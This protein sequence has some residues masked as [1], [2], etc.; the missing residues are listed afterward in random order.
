MSN[1]VMKA[2][3]GAPKTKLDIGKEMDAG[4]VILINNSKSVLG[5]EGAEFFGRFFVALILAAAEQRSGRPDKE[6]LPCYVYIDECQ[7]VIKRDT[8]IATI[9]DE[10]RSQKI[11]LILAHQRTEQIKDI[12]VLSALSN[13]AIRFA[14]SDDEA[15]Y[16]ADKLRTSQE[17]LR[18][19]DRGY[20]AAFVRDVTPSAVAIEVLPVD[21]SEY[22]Q[23][24][25]D[26]I[27]AIRGRMRLQYGASGVPP[28]PPASPPPPPSPATAPPVASPADQ[29]AP[30][31]SDA[32]ASW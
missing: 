21:F 25:S 18:S 9:L 11:G 31:Q 23:L 27:E 20:F 1:P 5:E 4:K 3:F 26:E 24:S 10:C 17:F 28:A 15:K 7:T 19:L 16:L 22:E 12:D 13:C 30:T 6:K 32:P 29:S 14:N 8:K 2:M